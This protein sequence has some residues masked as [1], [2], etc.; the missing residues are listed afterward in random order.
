[1]RFDDRLETALRQ[2][3]DSA[4]G[5]A[6]K[7]QQLVDILAQN[8]RNFALDYVADGLEKVREHIP[9]VSADT[10][11]QCVKALKGRIQ[12]PPLVLLLSGDIPPV[13]A[14][15]ISG[16]SLS[17]Q[18]WANIVPSMST[19]A[20]GFL[21][22]R[23]DL[24]PLTKRAL[25]MWAGADFV[26]P[27]PAVKEGRAAANGVQIR[28]IVERI[29]KLRSERETGEAPYLPFADENF[30]DYPEFVNEIR[31][32]TDENGTVSW[33]DGAPPGAVVG[34]D[35]AEPAFDDGPGPDAYGAAAFRQRMPLEN[36]R[37]RLC[38]ADMIAGDWRI[39]ASP[40]FNAINGRFEGYRGI[41]RR[42]T[43]AESALIST[44][45]SASSDH[46]QQL[47]HELRTPLGA[48]IG[49]SEIIEQQLFGP[50]TEDYRLLARNILNDAERLLA[51][52]DDLS[53]AA[54]IESGQLSFAPG[55]TEC[56]WLA[57]R[58]AERLQGLSDLLHVTLNLVQAHP[59]RPFA[60][61]NE[62][63]ERMFSRLL[64]AVIIG[65]EPN[66]ILDGRFRTEPGAAAT[67]RFILTLPQKLR[68]M[69]EAALFDLGP[70][71]VDDASE[72][73]LL[74][75]GFSL[76]LVR[77]LA[78]N[79]GG[80]LRFYNEALILMLPAV[81]DGQSGYRDEERE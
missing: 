19:R 44:D 20:R 39:N 62:I 78:R 4:P 41:F 81:S 30:R 54:K 27:E 68:Q 67:N 34:V 69:E 79:A 47:V 13:A 45:E 9:F 43:I 11:E 2:V 25:A 37:M 15:A 73:P 74:G 61:D 35:I 16:A 5:N 1:M 23:P 70:S 58:L 7:W 12:S 57:N 77:S 40:F 32:E 64:S 17:D 75:L 3:D 72:A 80:D 26:L 24:G 51:G 8:P 63:A 38:G 6:A 28:D 56:G 18:D 49:F 66:E 46:V 10:R 60:I 55:V 22:N 21:R 48:I 14:A 59:V 42:P 36:A 65:C 29:E 52:F 50:V 76:R 71:S 33:V 31:F 53:T